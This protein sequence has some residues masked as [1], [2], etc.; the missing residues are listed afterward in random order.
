MTAETAQQTRQWKAKLSLDFC[1]STHN[2]SRTIIA[3]RKHHGPLVIQKPFYPEGHPCH[4]YLLHPPGGLVGGDQLTLEANLQQN[5]HVVITTPGAAKFYRSTGETA[6]Q[7]QRINIAEG[8]LL[9]WLPQETIIYNQA[10]AKSQTDVNLSPGAKFTGWEICCLG[11]QAG[12]L[13]FT[14]GQFAQKI[15]LRS[16]NRPLVVERALYRG[17]DSLLTSPWGLANHTAVGTM[18]ITPANQQLLEQIRKQV[19]AEPTDMFSATLLDNIIVCRY[20][21]SQAAVVKK[22][23]THVWEIARPIVQGINA[24][25]PRIWNT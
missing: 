6:S 23:F 21:G 15:Q 12:N 7:I 3:A 4:I 19:Q 14:D 10:N 22:V 16:N 8:A 24:C 1:V 11:R 17:G 9:E 5:T 25:I 13:P 20:L 2:T 18:I